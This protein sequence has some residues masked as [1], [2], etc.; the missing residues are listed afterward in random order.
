[1]GQKARGPTSLLPAREAVLIQVS[2]SRGRILKRTS[3]C[4]VL[5]TS[6]MHEKNEENKIQ[7]SNF[8]LYWYR[9]GAPQQGYSLSCSPSSTSWRHLNRGTPRLLTIMYKLKRISTGVLW[10]TGYNRSRPLHHLL[11]ALLKGAIQLQYRT[12]L[13]LAEDENIRTQPTN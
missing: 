7:Q 1:M 6:H 2:D 13:I 10:E 11:L 3:E 9:A 4:N 8:A 5:Y 12:Q